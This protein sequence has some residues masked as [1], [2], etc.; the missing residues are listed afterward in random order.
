MHASQFAAPSDSP[1]P[2]I[3]Q[4]RACQQ[5]SKNSFSDAVLHALMWHDLH[6]FDSFHLHLVAVA[7]D[8][9][10][11]DALLNSQ[12]RY[13][14]NGL[15]RVGTIRSDGLFH[16]ALSTSVSLTTFSANSSL[17]LLTRTILHVALNLCTRLQLC[18]TA[19]S[20]RSGSSLAGSSSRSAPAVPRQCSA[21]AGWSS[22]A[23][24]GRHC[25]ATVMRFSF[26]AIAQMRKFQ[27]GSCSCGAWRL[28][29]SPGLPT[30]SRL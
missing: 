29:Q 18:S 23:V 28:C 19:R 5:L 2:F 9:F 16:C 26:H 22:H 8:L 20:A 10:N 1:A 30:A 21:P 24:A 25:S 13:T 4:Q 17:L 6:N 15:V 14:C 3:A 27:C 11:D 7:Q 12:L